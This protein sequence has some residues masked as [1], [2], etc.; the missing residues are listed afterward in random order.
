[1]LLRYGLLFDEHVFTLLAWKLAQ[2][3]KDF[4]ACFL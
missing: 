2:R 1:L 4:R 3:R